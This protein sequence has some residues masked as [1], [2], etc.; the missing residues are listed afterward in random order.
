ME[1]EAGIARRDPGV[2][3]L[4]SLSVLERYTGDMRLAAGLV[5]VIATLATPSLAFAQ[6]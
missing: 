4:F 2:R 1:A 5:L 3:S 6:T